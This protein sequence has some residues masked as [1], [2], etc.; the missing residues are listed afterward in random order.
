[1][2]GIGAD[3]SSDVHRAL[4]E[5][6]V[7]LVAYV[8]DA[9]N[10]RLTQLCEADETMTMVPLT[11]EEEGVALLAGAWLGGQRGV[12]AMQSSGIGNCVN[13]LTLTRNCAFPLLL[14]VTMRGEPGEANPWQMPMGQTAAEVLGL[15]GVAA[16]RAE[17]A[18]EVG[19]A[20]ATAGAVAFAGP[21][22]A[23]VLIAQ[24]VVGL[25]TFED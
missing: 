25:K 15:S 9:G 18:D 1:M 24:R 8:P 10:A 16:R 6:D 12:L 14:V 11:T 17:T 2:S 7:R 3:W 22:A 5:L 4:V 21:S 23:A 20:V 19:A 13:M